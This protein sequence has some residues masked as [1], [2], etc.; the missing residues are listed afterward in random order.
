MLPAHTKDVFLLL[1]DSDKYISETWAFRTGTKEFF[2][3]LVL[4][5][6]ISG[7]VVVWG[8]R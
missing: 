3:F 7:V 6:N 1:V 5:L 8:I 4:V 2:S